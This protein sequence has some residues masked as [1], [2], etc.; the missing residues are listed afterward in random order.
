MNIKKL[1]LFLFIAAAFMVIT[2]VSAQTAT[3]DSVTSPETA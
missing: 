3:F 2:P 1:G